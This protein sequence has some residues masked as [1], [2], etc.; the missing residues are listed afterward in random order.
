MSSGS[1][2][3]RIVPEDKEHWL[4]ASLRVEIRVRINL[5]LSFKGEG[6]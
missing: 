1:I 3:V 5:P 2:L 6:D 4:R